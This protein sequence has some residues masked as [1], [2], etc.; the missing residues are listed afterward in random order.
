M[1]LSLVTAIAFVGLLL[2]FSSPTRA[3]TQKINPALQEKIRLSN[4]K[5]LECHSEVGLAKEKKP[6][7]DLRKLSGLLLVPESFHKS[8]H[9]K[10]EC[11]AC[12]VKGFADVPHAERDRKLINWCDE[13]HTRAFLKIE[14]QFLASVH[15]KALPNTFTCVSCHDPHVFL[16]AKLFENPRD[17]VSQD[18]QVCLRCHGSDEQFARLTAVKRPNLAQKHA[19]LPN[20]ERHWQAVRCVDC[21]TPV[22]PKLLSHE[23][24][25]GKRAERNCVACHTVDSMLRVRLYTHLVAEEREKA[26]FLNSVF[27]N[28]AYVVGATRNRLL[29]AMSVSVIGLVLAGIAAHGLARVF[30]AWRRRSN[31]E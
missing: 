29:D 5:C 21:H 28:E 17:A 2:S 26:G 18:N 23:I 16:Q 9:G 7:L 3:E 13:C 10:V 11:L 27:L 12:H 8:N 31:G 24:L 14:D 25:D 1:F 15:V 19:W 20:L 6:D 4:E 22:S 30:F